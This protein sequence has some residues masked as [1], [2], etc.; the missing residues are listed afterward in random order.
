MKESLYRY[1]VIRSRKTRKARRDMETD[2][3]RRVLV[4]ARV[5]REEAMLIQKAADRAGLSV[6]EFC[7]RTLIQA[8]Q[9]RFAGPSAPSTFFAEVVER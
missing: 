7:R 8:A 9:E 1:A 2:R 6:Y 5:P 4:G 3:R